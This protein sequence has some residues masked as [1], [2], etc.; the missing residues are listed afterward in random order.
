MNMA[1]HVLQELA[2]PVSKI[3]LVIMTF[4]FC[5]QLKNPDTKHKTIL[6]SLVR[7]MLGMT[8]DHSLAFTEKLFRVTRL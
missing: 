3:L 8:Y 4:A 5:V 1:A 7:C 6:C 2:C